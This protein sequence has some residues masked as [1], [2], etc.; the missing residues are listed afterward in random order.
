MGKIRGFTKKQKE[1]IVAQ[2]TTFWDEATRKLDP[3][4]RLVDER[5]R[6]ARG[7]LPEEL[8]GKYAAY[9]DRSCLVPPDIYNNLNSLR[10]HIRLSLFSK[11][12]YLKLSPPHDTNLR[13]EAIIKAEATLQGMNDKANDGSGLPSQA[14]QVIYQALYGGLS[15]VFTKW[16]QEVARIP[17]R[18]ADNS[19]AL[20]KDGNAIF[21]NQ[22]VAQYAE[23]VPL[24]IRRVRWNPDAA[25]TKD[26]RIV[27]YHSLMTFSELQLLNRQS[28][29][30]YDFSEKEL[31]ESKFEK[32]K[33]FEYGP[34]NPEAEEGNKP[35]AYG[36]T[37]VE[38][39]HI[40]GLFRFENARGDVT[41]EDLIV[42]IGNRHVLLGLK[43]ND[44]PIPGYKLFT[45]ASVN[46]ESGRIWAMGVV[47]PAVDT[48]IEQ[49]V[50]RNQSLDGTNRS[51]YVKYI[52]DSAAAEDLDDYV[53]HSD[54]QILK[55]NL[56]GAGL[57]DV[58]QAMSYLAR[59][60][61]SQD[62]FAQA[63]SLQRETQQTMM[64]SDFLQGRDPN[65]AETATGVAALVSGGQSLTSHLVEKLADTYLRPTAKKKLILWNF[66]MGDVARQVTGPNGEPMTI[67]PGE[68]DLPYNVHVETSLAATSP[69]AQRRFVE[70]YPVIA[71]DPYFD[72]AMARETLIEMLDLPNKDRLLENPDKVENLID[73]ESAA[74]GFG[75]SQQVHPLHN[76]QAHN[77]GHQEYL[78]WIME[79]KARN[80]A[81]IEEQAQISQMREDLIIEHIE[82]HNFYIE[83]QQQAI[84][85]TKELGGN[86]GNLVQPDGAA[87]NP[88]TQGGRG[89]FT[90]R[91][92]R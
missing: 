21:T 2:A 35:N 34:D 39:Q 33:Y 68:I 71:N 83:Q 22:I 79:Q 61:T 89:N 77:E 30:H 87:Q 4:L 11:K 18:K 91:E 78:E 49:F 60:N 82:E 57:Q 31:R 81:P 28:G 88:R 40:R 90:P 84:G 36:D 8:E 43:R 41:F 14:D 65:V 10:A 53:E 70:V 7:Q 63:G 92:D 52:A 13:D 73:N 45:F 6:L 75:V 3:Q 62:S 48:F 56:A 67:Q 46:K 51:T 26:I 58:N 9:P 76:H 24:D 1:E 15:C 42:E 80:D 50:K 64:M 20:D 54:D 23:D 86:T 74:L 27:G 12:P 38:V 29:N 69:A 55:L 17:L 19:L 37:P 85:N 5:E 16:T 59:P 66:F 47:E 44:L 25:E 32:G 72:G